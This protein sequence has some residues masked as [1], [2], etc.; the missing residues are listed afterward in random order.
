MRA[1]QRVPRRGD[2]RHPP[3]LSAGAARR[4]RLAAQHGRAVSR[5][6]VAATLMLVPKLGF[7][8]FPG[9]RQPVLPG[10]RRVAA[11][12]RRQRNR[13]RRAV[14]RR[15]DRGRTAFRLAIRQHRPRQSADLLQRDSG[16]AA[17]ER[18]LH[19]CALRSLGIGVGTCNARGATRE[20]ED[21]SGRALQRAPVRKRSADRS[22]DRGARARPGYRGAHRDRGRRRADRARHARHARR[23]E[24]VGGAAHRSRH[25]HRQRRGKLAR[26]SGRRRSIRRCASPSAACRWRSSAIRLATRIRWFCVR[27]APT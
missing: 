5:L 22:A 9:K 17:V 10:R 2:G 14:R 24:S 11:R 6:L 16:R 18:R 1:L 4:A 27:R 20:A 23:F 8:L 13:S 21:V 7:S 25:E 12:H 26:R 15:C 19:L 3:H